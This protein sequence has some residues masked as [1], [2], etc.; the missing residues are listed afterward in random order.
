MKKCVIAIG[1]MLLATAASLVT[2]V[3]CQGVENAKPTSPRVPDWRRHLFRSGFARANGCPRTTTVNCWQ[4][5]R[6][7]RA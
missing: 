5:S 1:V 4:C 2:T 3:N 7:T 6:S